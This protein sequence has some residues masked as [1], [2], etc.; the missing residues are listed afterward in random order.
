MRCAKKTPPG[1]GGPS[2]ESG[3][4]SAPDEPLGFAWGRQAASARRR[5]GGRQRALCHSPNGPPPQRPAPSRLPP[6]PLPSRVRDESLPRGAWKAVGRVPARSQ[7]ALRP[8]FWPEFDRTRRRPPK[9]HCKHAAQR[10]K[11]APPARTQDGGEGI[12]GRCRRWPARSSAAG[13]GRVVLAGKDRLTRARP[14]HGER[15][16]CAMQ[17]Q[18]RQGGLQWSPGTPNGGHGDCSGRG[19]AENGQTTTGRPTQKSTTD[20]TDDRLARHDNPSVIRMSSGFLSATVQTFQPEPAIQHSDRSKNSWRSCCVV[21]LGSNQA[22]DGARHVSAPMRRT[23]ST[24]TR[25]RQSGTTRPFPFGLFGTDA[26]TF[27]VSASPPRLTGRGAERAG[28]NAASQISMCKAQG[29]IPDTRHLPSFK[30]HPHLGLS[31]RWA[32]PM[33][34]VGCQQQV[35]RQEV[36]LTL[37]VAG[38][39]PDHGLLVSYCTTCHPIPAEGEHQTGPVLVL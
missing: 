28:I 3:E 10:G 11:D 17:L 31:G 15:E 12:G 35:A 5:L 34:G 39:L 18:S 14:V 2:S 22:V 19:A 36:R 38:A 30:T 6:P 21:P 16:L 8:S 23:S 20:Q 32:R 13:C 24:K 27:L 26:H 33:R 4:D 7:S 37:S 25:T 1:G 29:G 9:R